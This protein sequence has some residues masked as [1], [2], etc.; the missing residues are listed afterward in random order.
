[1][2]EKQMW[3]GLILALL[4]VFLLV[5]LPTTNA[6]N[7]TREGT[8]WPSESRRDYYPPRIQQLCYDNW[9]GTDWN[10][11]KKYEKRCRVL[12]NAWTEEEKSN[13]P[14]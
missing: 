14:Y 12:W 11:S 6:I 13:S 4:F 8:K 5:K 10:K 3:I 1:M 2:T 9:Y 7:Y